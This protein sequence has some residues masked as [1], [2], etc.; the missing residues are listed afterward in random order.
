M[1]T[2]IFY[3]CFVF[4][5]YYNEDGTYIYNS[6]DIIIKNYINLKI[7]NKNCDFIKKYSE[8]KI[9]FSEIN[10]ISL[11]EIKDL[12]NKCPQEFKDDLLFL[13]AFQNNKY[14]NNSE[15]EF[16]YFSV[17]YFYIIDKEYILKNIKTNNYNSKEAKLLKEKINQLNIEN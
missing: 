9:L 13:N 6:N 5:K 8:N 12:Y 16:L 14:L 2:F 4:I 1:F 7:E 17:K 11:N 3:E 15:N 10:Y